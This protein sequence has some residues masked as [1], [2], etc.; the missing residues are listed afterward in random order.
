MCSK[1][2]FSNT[3]YSP[4]FRRLLGNIVRSGKE[5]C[6]HDDVGGGGHGWG[7]MWEKGEDA[8]TID[9]RGRGNDATMEA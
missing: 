6:G 9:W 8:T 3:S 2:C 4:P 5:V 1:L 7:T